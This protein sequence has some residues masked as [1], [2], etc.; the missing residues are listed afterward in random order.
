[1][2]ETLHNVILQKTEN[3]ADEIMTMDVCTLWWVDQCVE[4]RKSRLPNRR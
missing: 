1:M 4:E 2:N 3:I